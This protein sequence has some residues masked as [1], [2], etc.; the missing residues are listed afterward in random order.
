MVYLI[1]YDLNNEAKNY[2]SVIKAIKDSSDG[3]FCSFWRSSW[4]IKSDSF[5]ANEVFQRIKP[6]MDPDDRCL[7]IQ[8]EDNKDGWLA[9]DEWEF[10]NDSV[11]PFFR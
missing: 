5:T 6:H 8:V 10:I 2:E 9:A 1:T 7:V 4:L 3:T 11:F